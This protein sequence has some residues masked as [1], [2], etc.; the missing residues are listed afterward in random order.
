MGS[1]GGKHN[2]VILDKIDGANA[3]SSIA[4][5]VDI[6]RA[7]VPLPAARQRQKDQCAFIDRN[8]LM[9]Y[10]CCSSLLNTA[11]TQNSK[12]GI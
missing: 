10:F 9:S 3:K 2:C 4:A 7:V 1:R 6:V 8:E 12:P 11:K 5:L